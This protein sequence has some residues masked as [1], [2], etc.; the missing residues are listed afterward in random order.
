MR[1]SLKNEFSLYAVIVFFLALYG[2]GANTNSTI[3]AWGYAAQV[4]SG[5]E[6]FQPHH[7]LYNVLGYCWVNAINSVFNFDCLVLLKFLNA[8]FA[9]LCLL[10]LLNILRY[11]GIQKQ[12]I[13]LLLI[14]VGGSWGIMRF[15]TE[16]EA[17]VAPLLFS[18]LGSLFYHK[19]VKENSTNF[20]VAGLLAA[21]ATLFHQVMFFWWFG[22]LLGLFYRRKIRELTLY[23]FPAIAV[24]I[25]YSA[26]V[27]HLYGTFSIN[28]LFRFTF[29]DY[30]SGAANVG[31][32]G[33]SI[34]LLGIGIIRS[35]IQI[36]GYIIHL[37]AHSFWWWICGI[38]G[39]VMILLGKFWLI[40][41]A[42]ATVGSVF[43]FGVYSTILIL[44]AMFALLSDGNAEFLAMIPL[45]AAIL[46]SLT[47]PISNRALG[48]IASGMLI[49]NVTLG[50]IPLKYFT[51]DG[52]EMVVSHI[53]SNKTP[54][55]SAYILHSV[56]RIENE[57]N[58][59][60]LG[61]KPMLIKPTDLVNG[62]SDSIANLVKQGYAVYTDE[63]HRP[64]TLSR[65][66]IVGGD[67]LDNRVF[68]KFSKT[69]TDS[70]STITGWYYLYR[71][72]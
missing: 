42:K 67:S 7:L 2:W 21:V 45:L 63:Y 54:G 36:H 20:F 59:I 48:F 65:E 71:I 34:L 44:Q 29:S 56:P 11:I 37:F 49:W 57:L 32:G 25:I 3:D 8:A 23:I 68:D 64:A 55:Q 30:Y 19:G 62:L 38:M 12:T 51:L 16:N 15:A 26:V 35:F 28:L 14:L 22:L 69:P 60:G 70:V 43:F 6:L 40:K 61:G 50:L 9:V 27:Y 52:S 33:K 41:K 53:R 18:L 39:I 5:K 47:Q 46:L 13:F 31:L 72:E 58:Y 66:T 17:Y 1:L 24:P 10:V 4:A